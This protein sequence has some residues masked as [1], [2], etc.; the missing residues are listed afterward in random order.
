M[1]AELDAQRIISDRLR[2]QATHDPLTGLPNRAAIL[3]RLAALE[4]RPGTSV[5]LATSTST[6]SRRSTTGT[7][8]RLATSCSSTVVQAHRR[9]GPQPRRARRAPRR[10]RVRGGRGGLPGIGG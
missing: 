4:A 3:G 8:M 10:R 5:G 1:R 2:H 9:D 6:A 7:A